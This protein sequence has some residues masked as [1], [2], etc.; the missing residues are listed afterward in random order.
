VGRAAVTGRAEPRPAI[1]DAALAW[2]GLDAGQ[3]ATAVRLAGGDLH[4]VWRVGTRPGHVVKMV[5]PTALGPAGPQRLR[6]TEHVARAAADVGVPAVAARHRDGDPLVVLDGGTVALVFRYIVGE[7]G[8]PGSANAAEAGRMLAALHRADLPA[9][10]GEQPDPLWAPVP[11]Q[12]W[13]TLLDRLRHHTSGPVRE[14]AEA[15]TASL[16][17]VLHWSMEYAGCRPRLDAAVPP[18]VSHADLSPG[19]TLWHG[20]RGY[21]ID[22]ELAGW[23]QPQVELATAALDWSCAPGRKP[24]RAALEAFLHGY[25]AGGG[26]YEVTSDAI[27]GRA[28]RQLAWLRYNLQRLVDDPG[29]ARL[30]PVAT[31]AL[32]M[33][34]QYDTGH[35][36]WSRWTGARGL[37]MA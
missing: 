35:R 34:L 3:P 4:E 11:A 19:N 5:D 33:F 36:D 30:V 18:V 9:P 28:G 17:V 15:V 20:D 25:R 24:S 7:R 6:Y 1:L 21:L 16:P 37:A 10:P 2:F 8:R 26:R 14:L 27:L 13:S 31:D 12:D 29:L 32:T 22:W 23:V